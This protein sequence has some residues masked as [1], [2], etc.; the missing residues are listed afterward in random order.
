MDCL[1]FVIMDCLGDAGAI[2]GQGGG[3]EGKGREGRSWVASTGMSSIGFVNTYYNGEK[4]LSLIM[5]CSPRGI[6]HTDC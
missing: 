4:R 2:V 6:G 1:S 3:W 5:S